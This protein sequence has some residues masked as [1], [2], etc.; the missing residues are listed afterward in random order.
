LRFPAGENLP[1]DVELEGNGQQGIY[2]VQPD[3]V[4][5]AK[6]GIS[7]NRLHNEVDEQKDT[8]VFQVM[9]ADRL[10]KNGQAGQKSHGR[11]N[12]DDVKEVIRHVRHQGKLAVIFVFLE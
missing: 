10:K 8:K 3:V 6:C 9:L 5:M 11:C 1:E 4:D 7:E 12:G 2:V